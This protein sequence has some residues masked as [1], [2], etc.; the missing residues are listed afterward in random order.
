LFKNHRLTATSF[1]DGQKSLLKSTSRCARLTPRDDLACGELVEP[2]YR[3]IVERRCLIPLSTLDHLALWQPESSSPPATE[4]RLAHEP[5]AR[6]AAMR[7]IDQV[8]KSMWGEFCAS[9]TVIEENRKVAGVLS[10]T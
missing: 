2:A 10:A 1:I 7:Q 3:G 9:D 8:R 6:F 5:A 4:Y